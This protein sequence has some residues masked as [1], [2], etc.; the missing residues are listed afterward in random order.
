M[1][2]F[3]QSTIYSNEYS[4]CTAMSAFKYR[5]HTCGKPGHRKWECPNKENL[6]ENKKSANIGREDIED[7]EK[8]WL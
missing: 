7:E 6:N 1:K 3:E 4:D 2:S 8:S 5:C